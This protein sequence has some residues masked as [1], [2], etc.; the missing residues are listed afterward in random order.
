LGQSGKPGDALAALGT[1]EAKG[2]A[3]PDAAYAAATILAQ[4]GRI[5]E[6]VAA[7]RRALVIRPDHAPSQALLQQ[8]EG[9]RP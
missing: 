5:A 3:E 2:P 4:Q 6:A 8:L 7:V 1:A 9:R